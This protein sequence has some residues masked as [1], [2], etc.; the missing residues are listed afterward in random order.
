ESLYKELITDRIWAYQRDN[1]GYKNLRS[2][3]LMKTFL[4][5][6]FI[7][8][9][10]DFNSFIPKDLSS[11]IS[12]KLVSYYLRK[13]ADKPTLHDKIEFEIIF[14]CYYINLPSRLSILKKEGFSTKEITEI[15]DSL[16]KLTN[17]TFFENKAH[18]KDLEKI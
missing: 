17:K 1:Y 3:P 5:T 4:G 11:T 12:E 15:E 9:R 7:D 2:F 18:K 8:V 13:L 6:P 16:R 14:S 10:V